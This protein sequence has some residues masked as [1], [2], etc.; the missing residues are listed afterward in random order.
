MAFMVLLL[1]S[2][3]I[4]LSASK[5]HFAA[6]LTSHA[7]DHLTN[8]YPSH[9]SCPS[10]LILYLLTLL[11][12]IHLPLPKIIASDTQDEQDKLP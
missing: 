11:Q 12:A 8:L 4:L 2:F 9:P 1:L 7:L 3:W 6:L 10:S 5:H